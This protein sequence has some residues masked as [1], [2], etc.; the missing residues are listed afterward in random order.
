MSKR[1]RK[2]PDR[3]EP[4]HHEPKKRAK[5]APAKKKTAK[6]KKED[7]PKRALSA[8]M[9]FVKDNR[10]RIQGENEGCTF[11]EVGKFCGEAWQALSAKQKAPYEKQAEDDKKRAAKDKAA[12]AKKN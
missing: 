9:F 4:E 5:A 1:E 12:F 7:K 3:M 11:G 8:Y 10:V 6:G 2:A